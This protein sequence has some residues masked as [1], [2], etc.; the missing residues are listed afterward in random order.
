MVVTEQDSFLILRGHWGT[1]DHCQCGLPQGCPECYG[2]MRCGCSD[3]YQPETRTFK[4]KKAK[5]LALRFDKTK[6]LDS[7]VPEN[8]EAK[9]SHEES[10]AKF[11]AHVNQVK[12][13]E[14]DVVLRRTQYMVHS[15]KRPMSYME[16]IQANRFHRLS[17]PNMKTRQ[18]FEKSN[19]RDKIRDE[20]Q[21]KPVGPPKQT[22]YFC[23]TCKVDICNACFSS[24]CNVHNVQF[25]GAAYFHCKSPFHKIQ[26]TSKPND[27]T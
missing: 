7:Q 27:Q 10:G 6:N 14:G 18:Q 12:V 22:R 17:V 1:T 21:E 13:E 9:I 8:T 26:H 19:K 5:I 2:T 25:L 4:I 23:K 20:F 3:C 11:R 24:V 16:T 15:Q